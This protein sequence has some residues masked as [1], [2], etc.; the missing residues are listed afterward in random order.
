MFLYLSNMTLGMEVKKLMTQIAT[1]F[2]LSHKKTNQQLSIDKIFHFQDISAE[3]IPETRVRL[4]QSPWTTETQKDCIRRVWRSGYTLT[5]SP[6]LQ[7]GSVPY[8][9]GPLGLH[10]SHQIKGS[11]RW[12]YSPPRV[13]GHFLGP[14]SGLASLRITGGIFQA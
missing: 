2:R 5:T 6:L 10:F 7:T 14:H 9:E 4:K 13:V 12:T 3:K 11:P 8:W 1:D